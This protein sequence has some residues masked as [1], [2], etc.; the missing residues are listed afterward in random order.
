MTKKFNEVFICSTVSFSQATIVIINF[1]IKKK[2]DEKFMQ[3]KGTYD[4]YHGAL[5]YLDPKLTS[6]VN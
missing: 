5:Q 3:P 4:P 6:G 2:F 1:S